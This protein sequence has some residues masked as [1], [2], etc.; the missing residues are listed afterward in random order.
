M[1]GGSMSC[2]NIQVRQASLES[3]VAREEEE[4][5]L[6]RS[7]ARELQQRRLGRLA[8]V[9]VLVLVAASVLVGSVVYD[10][11]Q[12]EAGLVEFTC[13]SGDAA[14]LAD[15]CPP[16]MEW[17]GEACRDTTPGDSVMAGSIVTAL[18]PRDCRTGFLY[19][20]WKGRCMRLTG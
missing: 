15:L 1:K 12:Q 7:I 17:E 6:R 13:S 2:P 5:L 3:G 4:E 16:A 8:A 18:Q 14:C 9:V 19:V 10:Q 20:A 11:R